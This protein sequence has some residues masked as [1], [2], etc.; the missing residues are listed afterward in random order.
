MKKIAIIVKNTAFNKN[1]GG[2]EVHTKA[3]ID[4]LSSDYLID[5]FAPQR[6]LKNSVL[7]EG[8]KNFYFIDVEYKTGFFSDFNS[9]YWNKGLYNFFKTKYGEQKY[10]LIISISSAGYPLLRRKSEFDCPFLT[11]SH[12]TAFSE[13]KSLLNEGGFSLQLLRNTP[14]FL[15]N[16]FFK[17]PEFINL[18]DK[19]I[20]VSDYVRENL[21]KETKSKN[22]SKFQ[23]IFNGVLIDESFD[24][25]FKVSGKLNVIF[26]GRVEI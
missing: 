11:I 20:C 13:Y 23:T 6:E 15:Y 18:S 8:N 21:I 16:Y 12:G 10:D 7:K 1:F 17:Q 14:Y 4:L 19:I 22:R 24:K 9:S 25:E 3:I 2:L 5:V 26:S